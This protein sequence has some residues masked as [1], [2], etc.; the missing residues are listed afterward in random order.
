M[1]KLSFMGLV[2][3]LFLILA[4][5][6]SADM[7]APS[8]YCSKPYKPFEFT[9]Q[10]ELDNFNAEVQRYRNC[11]EEFVEEQERAIRNHQQ[12]ADD[13]IEEWNRF[14]RFELN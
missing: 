7:F 3:A 10:W 11:I 14:V 1:R 13:A 12:A 6:I 9:S 2:L 8:P 4:S 5:P